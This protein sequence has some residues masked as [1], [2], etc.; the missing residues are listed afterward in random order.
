MSVRF[1]LEGRPN[2]K[3]EHPVRCQICIKGKRLS[4][5]VG[6]SL[7]PEF[8]DQE[9]QKVKLTFAG[10]PIT[11]V[12]LTPKELNSRLKRIDS[13]FSDYED[14][15]FGKKSE[16]GDL[17]ELYN[18][19]FGTI[20]VDV[21]PEPEEEEE[22]ETKA[23]MKSLLDEFL[24]DQ[25]DRMKW[26]ELTVKSMDA[27]K[28][29]MEGFFDAF[30]VTTMDYFDEAGTTK[31]VDWLIKEKKLRNSTVEKYASRLRYFLR[32]GHKKDYTVL[33]GDYKPRLQ[34][35][36]KPIV[37]LEWD[38]LMKL[39]YFK[40][41][42]VGDEVELKDVYGNEYK[43]RVNLERS[44][45]EFVRD[46]FCFSCFTSLRIS[47]I[48]KL[49]RTNIFPK[50]IL[51]TT[52]KDVDSVKI[53]LND[54][55][56]AILNRYKGVEYPDNLALPV[57][58]EQQTN[59]HLKEVGEI[60]GLNTPVHITYFSGTERNDEVYAKWQ[61]L[62]C[63]A[64]RRTFISNAIMLGIPPQVV[65]KWSGHSS[66]EAMK[67]YIEIADKA[68]A[69][70]MSLFDKKKEEEEKKAEELRKKLEAEKEEEEEEAGE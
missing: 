34:Q 12:K 15:L 14:S 57:I 44:T 33:T 38:E 20:K 51:L 53:E 56:R 25:K 69:N 62:S 37:F 42:N 64:G 2:K 36:K 5:T 45:M 32:W 23:D 63:H 60:V 47:D 6:F 68:K 10:K 17:K 59:N 46:V 11:G 39:L 8:W 19:H 67:P 22:E 18:S 50:Y 4:T 43:K 49:K 13:F 3:G 9:G 28:V 55:S 21:T 31:Y 65:M 54:Y 52:K 30:S 61:L 16:V 29:H 40:F 35:T 7:K 66:I 70:A 26:R 48:K 27:F 58:S 24:N 41:P 1:F